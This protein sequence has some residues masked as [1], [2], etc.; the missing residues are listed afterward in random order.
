MNLTTHDDKSV[1][2]V[3]LTFPSFMLVISF[4]YSEESELIINQVVVTEACS[5][6]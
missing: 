1:G 5:K 6:F 2:L 3:A 4:K